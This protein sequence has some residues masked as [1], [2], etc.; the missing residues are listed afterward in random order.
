MV[1]RKVCIF[2]DGC[3]WHKCPKCYKEPNSNRSYWIPKLDKNIIRDKKQNKLLKKEGWKVIRIWEHEIMS[4]IKK[5][6][7]KIE[8]RVQK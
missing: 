7:K 1:S 6:V 5:T 3:F 2:V 4:D 8:T